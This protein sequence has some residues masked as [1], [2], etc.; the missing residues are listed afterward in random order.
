MTSFFYSV[1]VIDIITDTDKYSFH[2]AKLQK[3]S[4]KAFLLEMFRNSILLL[5]FIK[6]LF[7]NVLN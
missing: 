2:F 3:K 6:I 1:V 5:N 4:E 7:N